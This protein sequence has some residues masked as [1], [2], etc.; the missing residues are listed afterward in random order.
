MKLRFRYTCFLVVILFLSHI[1]GYTQLYFGANYHPHI[2]RKVNE[3]FR[4]TYDFG[5][6]W[7]H[8]LHIEKSLPTDPNKKYPICIGGEMSCPPEDCGGMM[9]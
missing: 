5:D 2:I 9:V 8:I 1:R 4:Y 3:P 7:D 6:S